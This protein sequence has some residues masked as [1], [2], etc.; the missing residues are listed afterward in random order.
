MFIMP[1]CWAWVHYADGHEECVMNT[2]YMDGN[3]ANDLAEEYHNY[4][5]HGSIVEVSLRDRHDNILRTWDVR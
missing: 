5:G 3:K 4:A 1:T 2:D